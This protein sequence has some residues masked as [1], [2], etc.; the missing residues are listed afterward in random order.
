MAYEECRATLEQALA[1]GKKKL[2][3]ELHQAPDPDA[4]GAGWALAHLAQQVGLDPTLT[5][6]SSISHPQNLIMVKKLGIPLTCYDNGNVDP[7]QFDAFFFVDHSG[8]TSRW[9]REEKIPADKLLGIID[10][11]DMDVPVPKGIY[12]DKRVVGSAS[13]IMAEYL[14][15]GEFVADAE[16]LQAV[17]TGLFLGIT[18][19]T[20]NLRRNATQEDRD[21]HKYLVDLIDN[22]IVDQVEQYEIPMKWQRIYARAI[23][24][25]DSTDG[26][27]LASAGSILPE[28][29]DVL[30]MVADFLMRT[31]GI[32]T[33]YVIGIQPDCVDLSMRTSDQ[34]YNFDKLKRMF[35]EGSAGGKEGAGGASIPHGFGES[36]F[37]HLVNHRQPIEKLIR[38]EF[39]RRIYDAQ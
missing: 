24:Q 10:H 20:T 34:T 31:Q 15:Q 39:H 7:G 23:E 25:S 13:T 8:A 27:A 30:P 29:R 16:K 14:Q 22:E 11:H 3:I 9:N 35:P 33:V 4:I 19:D 21:M 32:H 17:A 18:T 2:A 36:S 12:V 28:D 26:V 38:D 6:A 1:D 5:Y 37:V